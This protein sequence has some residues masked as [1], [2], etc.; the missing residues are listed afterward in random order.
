[1]LLIVGGVGPC[2][3]VE[4]HHKIL[5]GD[6]VD[7]LELTCA[8]ANARGERVDTIV[9]ACT[10]LSFGIPWRSW[11]GVSVCDGLDLLARSE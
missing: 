3:G 1:M 6:L 2:A 11:R 9:L 8:S 4:S 10:E 7:I 5:L